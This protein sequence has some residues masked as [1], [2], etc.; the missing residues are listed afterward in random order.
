MR[1]CHI[2]SVHPVTDLRIFSKECVSLSREGHEVHVVVPG[3]VNIVMDGVQ[4]HGVEKAK[5][6]RLKRMTGTVK[7][8]FEKAL[9]IDA[10][11]YHFHDPELIPVGLKFKKRGKIVVYDVHEDVPRQILTKQWLPIF[12]KKLVSQIFEVFENNSARKLDLIVAATPHIEKRFKQLGVKTV[13]VNNYPIHTRQATIEIDW[14]R[15]E[16]IVCYVGAVSGERGIFEMIDAIELQDDVSLKL[17]GNFS[18]HSEKE[19]ASQKPGWNQVIDYGYIDQTDVQH[20]YRES[21]AGLVVLHPVISY[22]DSLPIKMFEYMSAGI[23]VIAS[24]FPLWKDI[25]EVNKCGICVDPLNPNEIA[26]A[27]SYLANN[28]EKAER[29]GR[30]GQDAIKKKYNWEQE[31]QKLIAAYNSLIK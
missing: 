23:P 25:I 14:R 31:R 9:E 22:L 15:K 16:R 2:T 12:T 28:P 17:A 3:A 8:V 5:G 7:K 26:N 24:N 21:I 27:V 19:Q 1:V 11:I 4:I 30:N 18:V 29:M 6:N 20:I 13:N 10:D